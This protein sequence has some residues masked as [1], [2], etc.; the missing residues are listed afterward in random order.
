LGPD[1]K[2]GGVGKDRSLGRRRWSGLY[3]IRLKPAPS[4]PDQNTGFKKKN[5]KGWLVW[6]PDMVTIDSVYYFYLDCAY[7]AGLCYFSPFVQDEAGPEI[8]VRFFSP[9][10]LARYLQGLYLALGVL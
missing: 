8:G 5:L 10:C 2:P 4:N 3:G 7:I 9:H 1:V 6:N